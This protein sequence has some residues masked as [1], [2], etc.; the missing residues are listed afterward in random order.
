METRLKLAWRKAVQKLGYV[1]CHHRNT[2]MPRQLASISATVAI[3]SV[4]RRYSFRLFSRHAR[5]C[6]EKFIAA[7]SMNT[8]NTNSMAGE[9]K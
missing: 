4:S 2:A 9:L 6:V 8:I 7:S 1:P 3:A 5:K